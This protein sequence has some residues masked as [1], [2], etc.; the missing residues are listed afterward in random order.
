MHTFLFYTLMCCNYLE[1]GKHAK[2][3]FV[4]WILAFSKSIFSRKSL[5]IVMLS[6]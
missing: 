5:E 1:N 2:G 3:D 6:P 4:G